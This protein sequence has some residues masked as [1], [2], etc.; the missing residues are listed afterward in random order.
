MPTEFAMLVIALLIVA[1]TS[2]ALGF[3]SPTRSQ[4]Q[5]YQRIDK[6]WPDRTRAYQKGMTEGYQRGVLDARR[7][8]ED[9]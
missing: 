3:R 6:S 7:L 2:F 8:E 5:L 4:H 1:I 9:E